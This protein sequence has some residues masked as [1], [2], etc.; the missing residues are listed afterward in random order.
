MKGKWKNINMVITAILLFIVAFICQT[1]NIVSVP[2]KNGMLDFQF[3]I[4]T[5]ASVFAG[6]S[7]TV[8][9]LLISLSTTEAMVRLQETNILSNSCRVITKSIIFFLLSFFVSLYYVLGLSDFFRSIAKAVKGNI[10][11][12]EK[13]DQTLF[14][15]GVFLMIVGICLFALSV[16]KMVVLMNYIFNDNKK[17]V[18]KKLANYK[19]VVAS[20]KNQNAKEIPDEKEDFDRDC[21]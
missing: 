21:F 19:E 2:D 12:F 15:Y 14:L 18:A 5:I 17:E 1:Y 7:F 3:N 20:F 4:I 11:L 8:L 9:G 10:Q 16:Y 6:F 13:I